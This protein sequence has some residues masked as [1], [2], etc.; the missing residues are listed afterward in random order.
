MDPQRPPRRPTVSATT[1]PRATSPAGRPYRPPVRR[2]SRRTFLVRR[3]IVLGVVIVVIVGLVTVVKSVFGED[4]SKAASSTDPNAALVVDAADQSTT[5]VA[6][7]PLDPT[8]T[9]PTTLATIAPP[10]PVDTNR[11]PTA[12]DP[13]KVL[14]VG[15]S[16]AGGLSP[17]LAKVLDG[18]GV[19]AMTTDY[20]VSS[21]LVRPDFY[22]WPT[23]LHETVPVAAP[24]IV[25]AL[26]GGNDGQSFQNDDPNAGAAA[27]KAVDT[28]EWRAEYGR[29][30]GE[31]MDY[32]SAEGR[33]LIWV[34]VPNAEKEEFTARLAVQNE[35]V[36]AEVAKHPGVIF[37]DSWY[38]FTGID[39]SFAPLIMDPR[40]GEFKA[41]RSESDG[42]HLNTVGEEILAF[43]VG[44]AVIGDLRARGAAI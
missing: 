12:A 35:V 28:P 18:T 19:T 32:L 25:V 15:D 27:G 37:V 14:L 26:F 31:V 1:H 16:E 38:Q 24:D 11:T 7:V 20:K 34:G 40:D 8:L 3:L 10:A 29:R 43:V 21:G 2:P 6:G 13:A 22:D 4:A 33:T 42:F 39:G 44:N 36:K 23:H 30:V 41:V 17:F 9:A 5:S